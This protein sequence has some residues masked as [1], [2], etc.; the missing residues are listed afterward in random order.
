ML[1]ASNDANNFE[2]GPSSR[3]KLSGHP[4]LT[5]ASADVKAGA[6]RM[7][8]KQPHFISIPRS[9]L[10]LLQYSCTILPKPGVSS[11][12]SSIPRPARRTPL[13]LPHHLRTILPTMAMA[14]IK[15]II[16]LSFV[17]LPHRSPHQPVR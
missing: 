1:Q 16:V 10:V 6:F 5:R 3:F 9:L 2:P 13:P 15:T 14:G 11:A 12:A 8:V 4:S 17:R 7:H